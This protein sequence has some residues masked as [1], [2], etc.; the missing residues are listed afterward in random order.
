MQINSLRRWV[1][2]GVGLFALAVGLW[3]LAMSGVERSSDSDRGRLPREER[4]PL[5]PAVA[6][7]PKY[8]TDRPAFDLPPSSELSSLPPHPEAQALGGPDA[9]AADE[10]RVV[11]AVFNSYREAFGSYPT[12]E[13]NAQLMRALLG[14]NPGKRMLFPRENPR[15]SAA[16][17]LLDGYGTAYFFH[18]ISSQEIEV[19]SA[20][21]DREFYTPDDVVAAD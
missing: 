11:L 10:P 19:R 17:E 7:T 15:L 21:V 5:S 4:P 1:W 9:A 12:G 20:G 18:Q 16:G 8:T 2:A 13:D 3:F 6:A 14:A